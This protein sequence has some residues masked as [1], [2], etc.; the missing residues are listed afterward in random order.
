M[1]RLSLVRIAA[2]RSL[3]ATPL[4]LDRFLANM[5]GGRNRDAVE[6]TSF[7]RHLM[8]RM[9]ELANDGVRGNIKRLTELS[10]PDHVL[11]APVFLNEI[12]GSVYP[13]CVLP[14]EVLSQ[15]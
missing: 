14:G 2:N 12:P 3:S 10:A 13:S 9:C 1:H 15:R 4:K 8:Q 6:S 11:A 5:G 7:V